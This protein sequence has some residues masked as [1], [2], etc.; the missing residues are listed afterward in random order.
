MVLSSMGAVGL[1]VVHQY[2]PVFGVPGP[3]DLSPCLIEEPRAHHCGT[4]YTLRMETLVVLCLN[5]SGAEH[6][7]SSFNSSNLEAP[8]RPYLSDTDSDSRGERAVPYRGF[9]IQGPTLSKTPMKFGP[10][11]PK[12][13]IIL[14]RAKSKTPTIQILVWCPDYPPESHLETV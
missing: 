8:R 14:S 6:C 13:L 2:E 7:D 9:P 11:K 1:A 10:A 4:S 5:N 12:T 3:I